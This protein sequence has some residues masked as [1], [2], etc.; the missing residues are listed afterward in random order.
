LTNK[1]KA[2]C[3]F[4]ESYWDRNGIDPSLA[5]IAEACKLTHRSLARQYVILIIN[6]GYLENSQ[7]IA[8]S[9]KLI[10]KWQ[11]LLNRRFDKQTNPAV[12][13]VAENR[14]DIFAGWTPEEWAE[15]RSIR[16][17]G[18]ALTEEAVVLES[19]KIN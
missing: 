6:K 7:G 19:E 4:I 18:G 5:E 2:V 13:E 8:R 11:Q 3:E 15:L 9:L 12:D 10:D 17:V 16:G 14:P 1:Q